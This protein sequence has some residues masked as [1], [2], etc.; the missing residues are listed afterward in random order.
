MGRKGICWD[1]A[2]VETRRSLYL[3]VQSEIRFD[4]LSVGWELLDF[5]Q[6][7]REQS[8]Q[9]AEASAGIYTLIETAKANGLNPRKYIQYI[10]GDIPGSAFM[11]YP[12]YLEVYLP[13]DPI[14]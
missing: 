8:P 3:C 1:A 2:K 6:S 13:W 5:Q 12:E 10:L 9:G 4:E 11:Q 7:C 14:I